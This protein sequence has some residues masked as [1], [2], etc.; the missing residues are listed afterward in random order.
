MISSHPASIAITAAASRSFGSSTVISVAPGTRL[1]SSATISD[2][3]RR[4]L[5]K[6]RSKIGETASGSHGRI[7]FHWART[8]HCLAMYPP[9]SGIAET[10]YRVA[11]TT[12]VYSRCDVDEEAGS[13]SAPSVPG[14]PTHLKT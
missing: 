6:R 8:G 9:W 5:A 14:R 13:T 1:T 4:P 2:S 12:I 3:N 10:S 7:T 11:I